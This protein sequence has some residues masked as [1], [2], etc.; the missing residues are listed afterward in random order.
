MRISH[1][2]PVDMGFGY[3]Q[4]EDKVREE[5]EDSTSQ[6]LSWWWNLASS[7][8]IS[9]RHNYLFPRVLQDVV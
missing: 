3:S 8:K 4:P 1:Q 7:K 5:K 9:V 6:Q 2:T